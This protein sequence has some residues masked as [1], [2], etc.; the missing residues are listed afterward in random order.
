MTGSRGLP[1]GNRGRG[2]ATSSRAG[3]AWLALNARAPVVPVAV[4][5]T[6]RTGDR[7]G[8]IPACAAA[9]TSSSARR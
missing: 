8:H 7:L 3:A 5:G 2:D 1:E 9:C 4:L 6:R